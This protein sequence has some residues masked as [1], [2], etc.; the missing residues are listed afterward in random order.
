[1]SEGFESKGFLSPDIECFKGENITKYASEFSGAR[2]ISDVAQ[3]MFMAL[4]MS[5]LP[6]PIIASIIFIERSVRGCQAAIILCELGLIQE[7]QV[8][9]RTAT[10][11]LFASAALVSDD[12]AYNRMALASDY[13]DM[14]QA[15]G[16]INYPAS[17]LTDDHKCMLEEV[18]SRARDGAS[19]YPIYEAARTAGLLPMYET[20]YRGLSSLASHA[21]FRSLD[22]SFV[23]NG[24][25]LSIS[26]GPTDHQLI[27][28]LGL[29]RTCFTEI[30]KCIMRIQDAIKL[31]A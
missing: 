5:D 31:E 7:A 6:V 2:E 9:I 10:E 24:E 14:T 1:M 18:I 29:V 22:R 4:P 23:D 28:T 11:T 17:D 15:R 16:M 13:E 3:Q 21:T 8:L 19:K 20:F 12:N 26:L 30:I 27:F 25:E